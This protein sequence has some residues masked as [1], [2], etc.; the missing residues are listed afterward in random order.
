MWQEVPVYSFTSDWNQK[1]AMA[2]LT[3]KI[4]SLIYVE[5]IERTASA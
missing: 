3:L 4:W 5:H 2:T 1:M